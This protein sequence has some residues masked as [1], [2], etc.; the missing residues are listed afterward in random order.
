[1][2]KPIVFHLWIYS[3]CIYIQYAAH[4]CFVIMLINK[5]ASAD[6]AAKL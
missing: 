2:T 5:T 3:M 4:V 1:M 6:A